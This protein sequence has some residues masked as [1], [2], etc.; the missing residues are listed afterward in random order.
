[1]NVNDSNL[2]YEQTYQE[3][4]EETR[5]MITLASFLDTLDQGIY[6]ST[7]YRKVMN[8][9]Y[10]IAKE[11]NSNGIPSQVPE[12]SC[13]SSVIR[14]NVKI[15]IYNIIE[16]SVASL[17]Q[18]IYDRIQNEKCGYAEV[19]EQLRT[20]W[21]QTRL[22]KLQDPAANNNTVERISK[23]LLD[24]AI[25]NTALC[26]ETR[27]TIVG[28]NLES[29]NICELFRKHGVS[30]H[31]SLL[32]IG[33]RYKGELKDIKNRRNDLAHG[34]L[35]FTEAG[36]QVTTSELTAIVNHVDSF[37]MQLHEEVITYL[38]AKEYR[39]NP[40]SHNKN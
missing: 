23:E 20:I 2:G 5:S 29:D 25:T 27:K 12:V 40:V 24:D 13:V 22:H 36:S 15:M 33:N 1:M 4:L 7:N 10:K 32:S 28:G 26:F 21:R 8:E 3:R 9:A 31:S 35:S 6:D 39:Q 17:L 30:L 11:A 34:S 14:S 19:S 38:D 37:L 16:F 18:A